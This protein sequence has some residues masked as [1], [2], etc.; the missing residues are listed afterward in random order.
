MAQSNVKLT[1]DGSQATRALGQVQNKT[2]ALTGAVN[3]LRN[4][5]LGIGATAVVNQVV[6]QATSFE[7][8]N[9]RLKLLTK[10][11]GT[12]AES[13][14]LVEQAQKKFGL[15]SAEALEGV[16]NLQARLGPLGTSMD[17]VTA[18]FNGFNTAAILSGASAQ[19][20]AGAM[21]QLTQA[22]G[23]GVLRG[24]EFNSISEQMSAVQKPIADQLGINVGQ[25]RKYA[26]EGKITA[27]VVIKAFKEIEKEGGK[28]LEELIKQDPTMVFKLLDN[29]IKELSISVGKLFTPTVLKVTKHLTTLTQ[30]LT[31]LASGEGSALGQTILIFTGVALAAKAVMTASAIL[32]T[33]IIAL[34][35]SFVTMQIA[36]AAA[37]GQLGATTTMAFAAAGGFAKATAA[38]NAFKIALAKT[39]IGLAV[40][41]LGFFV[42]K[43]LEANTAQKEFNDLVDEG[44]SAMIN[45]SIATRVKKIDELKKELEEIKPTLSILENSAFFNPGGLK[46][47]GVGKISNEIRKINEEIAELE[48]GLKNAETRELAQ[49]YVKIKAALQKTNEELKTQLERGQLTTEEA[50][51][52]FD[53]DKKKAEFIE[54]F[55]PAEA[56]RLM[57]LEAQNKALEDQVNKIKE[58]KTAAE[59]L[60]EAFKKVG[61]S[62]ATNIRDNLV[63]A[64]K[65]TQTLGEMAKNIIDDLADSLI[66]LGITQGLKSFGGDF[67]SG[68]SFANGGSPPVGKA[69]LVGERGPELFVPSTAGTIVPNSQIGSSST[70][71]VVNVDATNTDVTGDGGQSEELGRMLAA[72]VQSELVNQQRPGG[73]LAGTR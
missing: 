61:D 69:S 50:K 70:N 51:K 1:V 46:I 54:Q 42:A 13:L 20:Q 23:S 15:S 59:E 44:T 60:K 4:A 25:L 72:A 12:Y 5:F 55:G 10:S 63:E 73:L 39:G 32:T 43:L 45:Q 11:Q 65:G 37:S 31:K 8:L 18:I 26:A 2:Q 22:L 30:E 57:Q 58:N 56:D 40:I 41:G 29:Q 64:V 68:L 71:I 66:R 49:E 3:T 24:E 17:D 36:A 47:R 27:K 33:Q 9:V 14:E 6:K 34:K 28:M 16:T 53:F 35:T 48:K 7:K 62:I 52:Q 67:F 19:E 21:R 38:A